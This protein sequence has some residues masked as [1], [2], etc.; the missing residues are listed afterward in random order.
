MQPTSLVYDNFKRH[1]SATLRQLCKTRGSYS[2]VCEGLGINRQQFSKYLSGNN[3]PSAFI[4]QKIISYFGVS[5]DVLFL[6]TGPGQRFAQPRLRVLSMPKLKE[7]FYL[8]YS[9]RFIAQQQFVAIGIWRIYQSQSSLLCRGQVPGH[10]GQ[11][12]KAMYESY[13]GSIT[14]FGTKLLLTARDAEE[15]RPY[16]CLLSPQTFGPNDL[17]SIGVKSESDDVMSGAATLF[18]YIGKSGDLPKLLTDECGLFDPA[19]LNERSSVVWALFT[20]QIKMYS[21]TL[22][23]K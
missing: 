2:E 9:Q 4:L 7:G 22:L 15:A 1:F 6:N 19:T 20:Q 3:L 11:Q 17:V 18:R 16:L 8:E 21:A 5:A 13:T 10:P 12:G 23:V 14:S